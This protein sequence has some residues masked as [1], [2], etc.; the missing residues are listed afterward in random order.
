MSATFGNE[1]TVKNDRCGHRGSRTGALMDLSTTQA[2]STSRR[3]KS[4]QRLKG[5][6]RS[7]GNQLDWRFFD[8]AR[9]LPV[10]AMEANGGSHRQHGG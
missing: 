3:W 2:D 4:H 6:G 1:D 9:M 5:L 7:G 10:Q 8:G